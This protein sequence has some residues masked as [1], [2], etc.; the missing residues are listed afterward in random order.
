[1]SGALAGAATLALA[2]LGPGESVAFWPQPKETGPVEGSD[3]LDASPYPVPALPADG[4][5]RGAGA[6]SEVVRV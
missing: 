3:E 1:M 4:P 5:A 6:D 2:H